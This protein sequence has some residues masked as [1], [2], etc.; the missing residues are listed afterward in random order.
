MAKARSGK[1]GKVPRGVRK[2]LRRLERQLADAAR[3]ELKRIR[4]LERAHHRRQE[5]EAALIELRAA[6]GKVDFAANPPPAAKPIA[7]KPVAAAKPTPATP[8][9]T[10]KPAVAAKPVAKPAAKPAATPRRSAPKP[11][12][13]KP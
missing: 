7:A 9:A 5:A 12:P 8:A 4:K 6:A 1:S 13:G 2:Q 11:P 3:L 10:A